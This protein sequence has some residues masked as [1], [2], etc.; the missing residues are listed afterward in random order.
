[1][2]RSVAGKDDADVVPKKVK[3]EEEEE[4]EDIIVLD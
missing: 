1:M 3:V 2:K 4:D